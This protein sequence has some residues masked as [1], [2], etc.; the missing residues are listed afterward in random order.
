M[1]SG[2]RLGCLGLVVLGLIV[3]ALM[4]LEFLVQ[5]AVFLAFG[6]VVYLWKTVPN[7]TVSPVGAATFAACLAG[8]ALGG[9]AFLRW[10]H[11]E[12]RGPGAGPWRVRW[13]ASLV[14][15]IVL[16][17]VAGLATAGLA[18]QIGWLV[19]SPVTL[20]SGSAHGAARRM[21]SV[22]NLKQIVLGMANYEV[23][24]ET[25]PPG[26]TT[27]ELGVLL[28]SWQTLI[29]PFLE[30][31]ALYEK[32][33]LAKPWDDLSN[34]AATKG[35]VQAYLIPVPGFGADREKAGR[36]LSH[37]EG[38][39]RVVGG[40]RGLRLAQVTDGTSST[41]LAGESAG[42]HLPWAM[43]GHARDPADGINRDPLRGFGGPF[44]GGAN[45]ILLDGSVRFIKHTIDPA[46]L[47]ALSTPAGGEKISPDAY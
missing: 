31:Q 21:Q 12:W 23:S 14:L 39:A 24:F 13:T 46:V 33:N 29:L 36:G 9:H 6:W 41:I 40:T 25:Y 10:L 42:G 8:F 19:A 4:G 15:A 2:K 45:V 35:D 28:H 16:M 11:R 5:G 26:A 34:L 1:S 44:P 17:F 30:H 20:V 37:Y 27:G 47:K 32:I 18:H 43:P 22:N 7:V 38:N 3:L